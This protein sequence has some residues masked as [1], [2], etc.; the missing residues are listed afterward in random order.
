MKKILLFFALAMFLFT[1]CDKDETFITKD[2]SNYTIEGYVFDSEGNTPLEGV[3][4]KGSFGKTTTNSDGY[5]SISGIKHGSY[6][7][8]YSLDG[9]GTMVGT[10]DLDPET[11]EPLAID[12][13]E[14][15]VIKMYEMDEDL[16]TTI[17]KVVNNKKVA[18]ANIPY[19]ITLSDNFLYKEI[20]GTT[21]A[22]GLI[23]L[24]DTLPNTSMTLAIKYTD[25]EEGKLYSLSK[26]ATPSAFTKDYYITGT[27]VTGD[28][29]I[30][31]SNLF[32]EEGDVVKDFA[33]SG[34]LTF[35]FNNS[36]A[37]LTDVLLKNTSSSREVAVETAISGSTVTITPIGDLEEETSYSVTF[38]VEDENGNSLSPSY[39]FS[40]EGGATAVEQVTG[41]S[42]KT[43]DSAGDAI[44]IYENTTSTTIEFLKAEGA[45]QYEIYAKYAD[46]TE[47]KLVKTISASTDEDENTEEY[48]LY[49]Y[50]SLPDMDISSNG[51]FADGN[52]YTIIVRGINESK[53]LVGEFSEA[54]VIKKTADLD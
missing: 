26:T 34:A 21:D 14:S 28:F 38:D 15:V 36:I 13:S 46:Q 19:T 22:N 17:W 44:E 32:D 45:T 20:E 6:S 25:S 29:I 52:T 35:T 37:T 43:K 53:D 48:S 7:V 1:A 49:M 54:L 40:T 31:D 18:M 10:Y 8:I 16:E 50:N 23:S 27:D 5:F 11:D 4:V 9:Y 12:Y 3:L 24:S 41:L 39:N 42:R 30:T 33:I 51:M 47:Y 2:S